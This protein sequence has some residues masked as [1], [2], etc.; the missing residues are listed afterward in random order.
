MTI[1]K[2]GSPALAWGTLAVV[3]A[4]FA[5]IVLVAPRPLGGEALTAVL[6][7]VTLAATATFAPTE[8][9]TLYLL[10]AVAAGLVVRSRWAP[11]AIAVTVLAAGGMALVRGDA[12][13]G[14]LWGGALPTLLAGASVYGFRRLG[15]VIGEL[16]RTRQ[17]LARA[18]V[19]AERARFSRDLHD[20]LGHTLSVIVVKAE[21]VRRLA[22]RDTGAAV[23]HAADIETIGREA[24]LEVRQAVA[25]YRDSGLASELDRARSALSAAGIGCEVTETGPAL[26][27][28]T[29]LLLG[30]VVR[31][32][33]TN[34]VRH[35]GARHCRIT[36]RRDAD[37]VVAEISDDGRGARSAPAENASGLHG[38]RERLADSG[39]TLSTA[40]LDPGFLLE[41]RVPAGAGR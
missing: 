29:D 41:A 18:A 3:A 4:L 23:G 14:A 21:A 38:L 37:P 32:G 20:L 11:A 15:D 19:A 10:V 26:S 5:A 36:V 13:E 31:E 1:G 7:A 6:A 27:A 40:D 9:F 28:E 34:V 16:A 17:E 8:W 25:G 2:A 24:L 22:P 35:S 39:G 33:V 30:W 12:V